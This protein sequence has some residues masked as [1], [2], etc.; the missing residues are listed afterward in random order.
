MIFACL[1]GGWA[2]SFRYI[3]DVQLF[4]FLNFKSYDKELRNVKKKVKDLEDKNELLKME[5]DSR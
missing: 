5:L 4:F 2:S 3:I 1:F